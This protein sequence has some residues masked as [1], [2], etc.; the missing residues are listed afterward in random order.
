MKVKSDRGTK[1]HHYSTKS[2][3]IPYVPNGKSRDRVG[4]GGDCPKAE[5]IPLRGVCY[6]YA[7][8]S[9]TKAREISAHADASR[10]GERRHMRVA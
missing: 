5:E 2:I 10:G 4:A 6:Q 1:Q 7:T 3:T 9:P 8:V